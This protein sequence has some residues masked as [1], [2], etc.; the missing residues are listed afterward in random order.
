MTIKASVMEVSGRVR[1]R[2]WN[3]VG[4]T[5][6]MSLNSGT[7]Y[8]FFVYKY[9]FYHRRRGLGSG[10]KRGSYMNA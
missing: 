10:Y 9:R 1:I 7:V 3:I 8:V 6:L 4:Q 2:L 5:Q